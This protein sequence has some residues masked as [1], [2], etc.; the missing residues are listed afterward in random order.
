MSTDIVHFGAGRIANTA[1]DLGMLKPTIVRAVI[2]IASFGILNQPVFAA[3]QISSAKPERALS[4]TDVQRAAAQVTEAI[5]KSAYQPT[6]DRGCPNGPEDRSSDL[7]AQWKAADAAADAA[8]YSFWGL[9][10]TIVG[11]ILLIVTLMQSRSTTRRELRAYVSVKP[12]TFISRMLADGGRSFEIQIQM[13]NGGA[14]PAYRAAHLGNIVA[15]KDE[16]AA[17]Y[18][19]KGHEESPR[20]GTPHAVTIHQGADSIGSIQSHEPISVNQIAG[21]KEGKLKLYAFGSVEYADTF[22][23][24]RQTHFCYYLEGDGLKFWDEV[25]AENEGKLMPANGPSWHAS[26]FHNDAT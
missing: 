21:I 3:Q 20:L 22:N 6:A 18:F 23:V 2:I 11:T 25:G 14:T 19:S 5:E 9:L 8:K 1:P 10:A 26:P 12:Q 7:C 16:V 17:V 24:R 13:E 15:L 4:S